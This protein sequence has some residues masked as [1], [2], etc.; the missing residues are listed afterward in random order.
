MIFENLDFEVCQR[1]LMF[2][3][4]FLLALFKYQPFKHLQKNSQ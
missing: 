3:V 4:T 2:Y 1:F